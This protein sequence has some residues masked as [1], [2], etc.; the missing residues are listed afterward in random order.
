MAKLLLV[1][2]TKLVLIVLETLLN[3]LKVYNHYLYVTFW[4]I[5]INYVYALYYYYV[6]YI[7]FLLYS[8]III[9][10]NNAICTIYRQVRSI[11]NYHLLRMPL[12]KVELWMLL[13]HYKITNVI[14]FILKF[15]T[16]SKTTLWNLTMKV[17]MRLIDSLILTCPYA[18]W[19]C[20]TSM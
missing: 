4:F 2:D 13:N 8:I 12:K 19:S 20:I 3:F 5:S 14:K 9:I 15:P 10:S 11:L 17:L 7:S 6:T 18:C 1:K 16:F